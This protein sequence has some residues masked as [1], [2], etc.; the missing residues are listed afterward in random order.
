MNHPRPSPSGARP[1]KAISRR[2]ARAA[3]PLPFRAFIAYA[4][5]STMRRAMATIH[6]VLRRSPRAFK[7]EPM[8]WRFDQ[9][10]VVRW[11][12]RALADAAEAAVVVLAAQ[13]TGS[14]PAPVESWVTALLGRKPGV[15]TTIVALLG[16]HD[17]WTISIEPPQAATVAAPNGAAVPAKGSCCATRAVAPTP[18][19][20]RVLASAA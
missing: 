6:D 2:G 3:E 8:L 14:L 4:D 12:D 1:A 20:D 19:L 18:A 10:G 17:A 16:D 13:E 11:R 9:L 15:R 5:F 7:F